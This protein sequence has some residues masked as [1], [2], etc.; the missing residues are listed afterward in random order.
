[1]QANKANEGDTGF[2]F[3]LPL[4]QHIS[5]LLMQTLTRANCGN[6]TRNPA[7]K[8]FELLRE[9]LGFFHSDDAAFRLQQVRGNAARPHEGAARSIVFQ[10]GKHTP[11][12]PHTCSRAGKLPGESRYFL[13]I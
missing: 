8:L 13:A 7:G 9:L 10:Q 11:W 5:Q 1:M 12:P 2:V 4:T 6:D 3:V